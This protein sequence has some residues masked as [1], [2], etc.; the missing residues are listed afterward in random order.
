M[1]ELMAIDQYGET[2]HHLGSHPRKELLRR[3]DSQHC[4]KMYRDAS[5]GKPVHVGYVISG[6]WLEIFTVT[7]WKHS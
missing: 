3:L 6:R 1:K 7:E 5:D 4:E 2:F